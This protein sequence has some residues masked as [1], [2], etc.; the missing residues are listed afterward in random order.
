MMIRVK[1]S[2]PENVSYF[3]CIA[4]DI[5]SIDLEEY[6]AGVV[7][8][9]IGNSHIEACKAQ[10]IAARTFAMHYV[11]DD[12][13][14]TDKS[15]SH[16]A[17]RVSRWDAEKYPNVNAAAMETAGMVLTWCGQILKT[18]SYSSSNGGRTVSSQERWG[19]FRP[20]LI[21]QDDP[22]DA[23]ACAERETKGYAITK[24][25][26]V[27]MSQYGA[28]WAA[29]HGVGYRQILGFYYVGAEIAADYN[30]GR[31]EAAEL[32]TDSSKGGASGLAGAMLADSRVQADYDKYTRAPLKAS[33]LIA[34]FVQSFD[35]HWGYIWGEAGGIWTQNEQDAA[36]RE[37][38]VLY[39]QR[40]V[41]RKVADCSG[42]LAWAVRTLGGSIYHGSNTI[43]NSYTDPDHRGAV[44]GSIT[45]P[46][47]AAVFQV[48]D[49]RRTHIGLYIGGGKCIEAR[50]TQAGVIESDISIWDEWAELLVKYGGEF[51]KVDYDLPYEALE[52]M[53]QT[54]RKGDSGSLVKTLQNSL[55]EAGCDVGS[56]GAD[57][58]FGTATQS[59]VR[60]FQTEHNLN[61]DGIVGPLT[62]AALKA[63]TEDD[64]PDA[65]TG[66][67]SAADGTDAP[68]YPWN[69]MTTEERTDWLLEAVRLLADGLIECG[70]TLILQDGHL[71]DKLLTITG[72]AKGGDPNAAVR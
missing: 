46:P 12:K 17:F 31:K 8:S 29:N 69:G 7:A 33:E 58:H 63:V 6:V 62:W 41:G 52:I 16:Q 56:K 42:L 53:P 1:L 21:A 67:S 47:G 54:L 2:R 45:I 44:A 15:S 40:W 32:D 51:M 3:G 39:G 22:W 26:G 9:E 68:V 30:Q 64:E 24:G 50:G 13:C 5:V 18:C 11:G 27:G 37:Q 20:Y 59:A 55:I 36:T 66:N 4:G 19:G 25:H 71:V 14:I 70:C 57:G 65:A 72:T 49:G 48:S 35:E 60:K 23:A 43:W 28:A 38:T 10:A 61:P 34:L